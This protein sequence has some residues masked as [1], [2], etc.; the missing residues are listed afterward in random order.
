MPRSTITVAP[1]FLPMRFSNA[2][3]IAST[4]DRSWMLPSKTSCALGN[5]SRSNT[6]PTTTCLAIGT[7]VAR[8]S[9]FGLRVRFGLALEIRGGQV[10]EVDRVVQIEQRFLPFSQF[11]LN[12]FAVR[13]Q[14]VQVSIQ[15]VIVQF[16]EALLQYISQSA[17]PDP[18]RHGMF[19]KRINQTI[20]GHR[21][22]QP[23]GALG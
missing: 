2:S 12:V 20:Q 15:C 8:V 23:A 11:A 14:S 22:G 6:S 4:L 13:M 1:G 9:A 19:G 17:P 7:L 18:V 21:F 3:S 16:G 5:P 10:V